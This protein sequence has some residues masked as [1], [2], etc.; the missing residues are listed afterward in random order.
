[1]QFMQL[2]PAQS[3]AFLCQDNDTATLGG[4]V[5][6]RGQLS[7]IG[8]SFDIDAHGG[9]QFHRL[10]IAERN[11]AGLVQEQHIDVAGRFDRAARGRNHVGLNHPIHAGDADRRE[12]AADRRGNQANQ[13]RNKH[14]DRDRCP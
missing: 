2:A 1:M 4:F 12:Q 7:G 10:T 6:E 3:V 5:G 13:E 8:E 14:R 11:R 9:N